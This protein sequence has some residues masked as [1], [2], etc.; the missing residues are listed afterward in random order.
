MAILRVC[1][2]ESGDYEGAIVSI[3]QT[4]VA[5]AAASSEKRESA[6]NMPTASVCQSS[7]QQPVA[8]WTLMQP[9]RHTSSHK[10]LT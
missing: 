2:L 8:A 7:K 6:Q 4:A 3:D 1:V 10:N 5:A 9:L